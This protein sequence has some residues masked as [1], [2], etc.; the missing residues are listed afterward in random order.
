MPRGPGGSLLLSGSPLVIPRQVQ[1]V[2]RQ[3]VDVEQPLALG[4]QAGGDP[5]LNSIPP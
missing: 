1:P 2:I 5:R 3:Q 4:G